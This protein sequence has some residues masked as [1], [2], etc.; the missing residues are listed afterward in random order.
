MMLPKTS[1][2]A[3]FDEKQ[4]KVKK[5]N[6]KA[7]AIVFAFVAIGILL[8]MGPLFQGK[9]SPKLGKPPE[10]MTASQARALTA[11]PPVDLSVSEA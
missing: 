5:L 9:A 3:L 2:N 8:M 1:P 4:V 10:A 7:M 6:S 11:N